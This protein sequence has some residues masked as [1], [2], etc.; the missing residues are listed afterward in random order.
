[1]D[2]K[3][4]LVIA[5]V[6][7]LELPEGDIADCGV[8]EAVGQICTLK[9][10]HCDAVFL[11]ELLGDPPRNTVQLHAV[12][13]RVIHAFGNKPHKV[14]DAA[15]GLQYIAGLKVHVLQGT[16]HRLDHHGRRIKGRQRGFSRRRI[17]LVGEHSFQF[18][19][20]GI[21]LLEELGETAPAHIVGKHALLRRCCQPAFRVQLVQKL[22]GTD[23]VIEPFQRCAHA[24]IIA[25]D[26]E[27]GSVLGVDFRMQ[28]MRRNPG[29]SFHLRRWGERFFPVIQQGLRI[30]VGHDLAVFDGADGQSIQFFVR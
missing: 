18:G 30:G 11:I 22:N 6:R 4:V 16:V 7:H 20:M 13:L 23:I 8:K 27:V 25:L 28:H 19:I 9:A 21:I 1:M 14:S 10:L 2:E 15:G 12:E 24:D 26:L 3:V 17:L 5:L 29:G